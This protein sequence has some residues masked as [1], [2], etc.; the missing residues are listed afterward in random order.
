MYHTPP[1]DQHP[2]ER[3]LYDLEADPGEFNNLAGQ[4]EHQDLVRELHAALVNELGEH[5]DTIEQRCRADYA[6]GYSRRD[7]RKRRG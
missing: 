6:R 2:A 1:D 7:N 3:D 5:P 4:E